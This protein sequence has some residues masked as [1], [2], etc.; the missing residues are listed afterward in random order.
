MT[1]PT[2]EAADLAP[3]SAALDMVMAGSISDAARRKAINETG[4]DTSPMVVADRV[5]QHLNG[6]S[7]SFLQDQ[8]GGA[9]TQAQNLGRFAMFEVGPASD[10]HA[11]E[12][13]DPSCCA[14]CVHVD[15]TKYATFEDARRDYPAMLYK[16]CLGGPRCRGTVVA[17]LS[18]ESPPAVGIV[19]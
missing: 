9:V 14:P 8:L 18:D 17:I 19:G 3:R 7:D 4:P 5:R 11:S 12:L 6:L 16:D 1:A 13:L 15:G 10:Y 2:I